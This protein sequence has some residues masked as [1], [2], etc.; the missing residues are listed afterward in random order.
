MNL[1]RPLA[2]S[3]RL[4]I[5]LH[6]PSDV[7]ATVGQTQDS[8]R[9]ELVS[10]ALKWTRPQDTHLTLLFLGE[11]A[12]DLLPDVK[13]ELREACK[14]FSNFELKLSEAGCFPNTRRPRV[15]WLGLGGDL[16]CLQLLYE[17]V[18]EQCGTFGERR[19]NKPFRP[20]LTLAR[21]KFDDKSISSR[22]G[23]CLT[24]LRLDTARWRAESVELVQSELL[25]SG[26]KYSILESV[27]LNP[28][29]SAIT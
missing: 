1:S 7:Q 8:L 15:L 26:A 14:S 13:A 12:D 19:N 5:A 29:A 9:R 27:K 10:P 17:R 11:V 3:M 23:Q 2:F 25:P 21:I 22:L 4:F 16:D 24:E 20:H 28:A 6:L 18:A